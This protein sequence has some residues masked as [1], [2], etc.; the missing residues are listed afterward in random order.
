MAT[1]TK[2]RTRTSDVHELADRVVETARKA[3][4]R[5]LDATAQTADRVAELQAKA[6]EASPVEF[7]STVAE[8]QAG[9]T[10]DV[11]Q[12]YVSAGRKLIG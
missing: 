2:T 4:N 6:G 9:I 8:A 5:Y 3:G 11:A 12:A 7:V 1:Q 10:R